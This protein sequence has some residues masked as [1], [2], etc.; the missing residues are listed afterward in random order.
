MA[1]VSTV[2]VLAVAG[3]HVFC[4]YLEMVLF[5]TP[6]GRKIFGVK[7]EDVE[8]MKVLAANQGIYNGALAAV[9]VWAQLAGQE[10]TVIAML[11]F[12]IVVG[13]YGA[14]TAARSILFIQVVPAAI[15]LGL[16]FAV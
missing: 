6:K 4:M 3:L 11:L 8:A 2:A 7:E 15:A 1:F 16:L 13:L 12:V 10:Q 14:A 5:P 9:L